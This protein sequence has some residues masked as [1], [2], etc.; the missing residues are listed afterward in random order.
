MNEKNFE[1]TKRPTSLISI[2]PAAVAAAEAVKAKV[3]AHFIVAMQNPRDEEFARRRILKACERP[4]FAE[5]VEYSRQQ[6]M[7]RDPESGEWVP[8][9]IAG[10]SIRFTETAL[11][12]WGN[13]LVETMVL[14]EDK[15]I[16]R[17]KVSATDCETNASFSKEIQIRKTVERK[18]SAGRQVIS[19]R[20]NTE[21]KKVYIVVATDE[22]VMNKENALV[23]KTV[24]NEGLRLIPSDL[25][26]EATR[27]ARETIAN[28][29]RKNPADSRTEIINA[30]STF[31][32][33]EKDLE[34]YL[35][36]KVKDLDGKE[37]Q[38]LRN[39]YRAIRDGE[40][41]W[42]DYDEGIDDESGGESGD[43]EQLALFDQRCGDLLK[44][45]FF[46]DYISKIAENN[47]VTI[48]EVK[49]GALDDL[50]SFKNY[51]HEYKREHEENFGPPADDWEA[52]FR[53]EWIK[54]SGVGFEKYMTKLK[55]Q[56][57]FRDC[58]LLLF[59]EGRDKYERLV[60]KPFPVVRDDQASEAQGDSGGGEKKKDAGSY[61]GKRE[62]TA[63]ELIEIEKDQN[64]R[65][66]LKATDG[67]TPKNEKDAQKALDK[68]AELKKGK[69]AGNG[70]PDA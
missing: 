32:I 33:S 51:F 41:T 29:F 37:Y 42:S 11:K 30:F 61:E 48:E 24:R 2:D 22:E 5:R 6:G 45:P 70:I 69:Q 54:K 43:S 55:N 50:V 15:D 46:N 25:K 9:M 1:L 7:K 27:I 14:Y 68:I 8:N 44:D 62:K 20:T 34:R 47:E 67:F 16:R 19:E 38:E 17:I 63:L 64:P 52:D 21:G 26:D 31:N 56:K 36:H 13:I 40:T 28:N 59:E 23:S 3:Q 60:R 49:I 66:Y 18:K 58:S 65:L 4:E 53:D 12:E 57:K 10:L 35:G 39:I